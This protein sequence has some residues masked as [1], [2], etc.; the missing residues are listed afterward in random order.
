MLRL[1]IGNPPR[2]PYL[3]PHCAGSADTTGGDC[4]RIALFRAVEMAADHPFD[5]RRARP[6]LEP[7][8]G[9]ALRDENEGRNLGDV[10]ALGQVGML[11]D[12]DARDAE[13]LPLLARQVCQQALHPP[14]RP[15]PGRS[16][17]EEEWSCRPVHL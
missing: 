3:V 7:G 9:S 2:S 5:P 16:E 13:T 17:E 8:D 11:V 14:A 12:V 1:R 6:A 4:G 10:E 15:R